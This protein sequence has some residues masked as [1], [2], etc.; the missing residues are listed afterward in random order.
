MPRNQLLARILGRPVLLAHQSAPALVEQLGGARA[1][2]GLLSRLGR[3][4][5]GDGAQAR[6]GSRGARTLGED[7]QA[8][9][10]APRCAPDAEWQEGGYFLEGRVA[11]IE[12][13]GIL[14]DRS[15]GWGDSYEEIGQTLRAARADEQV[16][17]VFLSIDSPGGL[18]DGLFECVSEISQGSARHGGK[19]IWAFAGGSAFSAAYAIASACDRIIASPEGEVGSIGAVLLHI[20]EA[21]W[22]E[23]AGIEVTPIEFPEGK[24]EGAW[25]SALSDTARADL[26]ARIKR[27]ATLF[28]RHVAD[29]RADLDEAKILNLRARVFSADDDD[30]ARSALA[31]GLID[32][33]AFERAALG[34]FAETVES[35]SAVPAP[36]AQPPAAAPAAGT[37]LKKGK[38]MSKSMK[39]RLAELQ[40]KA[41]AGDEEA[42]ATLA[43]LNTLLSEEDDE[44]T[45][46]EDDDEN[47]SAEDD[48][49]DTSAEDDDDDASAEDDDEED[50][51]V[52]AKV[53]RQIL[54]CKEAKGR[55]KLA[56]RLATTPGMT[57]KKAR[58]LLQA[59]GKEASG[60]RL[61]GTPDPAVTGGAG[62]S[63]ARGATGNA[64]AD[65]ALAAFAK[66]GQGARLRK[67][68]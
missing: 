26:N 19:P 24:T 35:G 63:S 36:G 52:D 40:R 16:A 10:W 51:K 49:E 15:V 67:A 34:A 45:S 18:V 22:L 54:G 31:L 68:G 32:E 41:A 9:W 11:V 7:A 2:N 29:H 25:W 38:T 20:N 8:G 53:A 62:G 37:S 58:G 39:A 33:I 44:N 21:G 48:D 6:S 65:A 64:D 4:I 5:A 28:I 3:M 57:L 59:A 14:F 61:S 23:K 50:G 43:Q 66:S 60:S 13:L 30:P 27:A 1:E 17:G 55:S 47:T 12:V 46:A 42:K 56:S